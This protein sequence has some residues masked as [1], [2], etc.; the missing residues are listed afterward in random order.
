MR[1]LLILCSMILVATFGA[2]SAGAQETSVRFEITAVGDTSFMF[3]PG[4]HTWVS[5]G[6]RG[7]AVDPRRR[8]VMVARFRVVEVIDGV[9]NAV[10]TGQTT[11][12]ATDHVALIVQPDPH[13]YQRPTFW[14]GA[15]VGAVI[16]AVAGA[17][18]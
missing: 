14:V 12:I 5:A 9:A 7:I 16:G 4:R 6:Q 3:R 18:L 10:I 1:P 11:N 13:W 15:L 8:D 17:S 2:T